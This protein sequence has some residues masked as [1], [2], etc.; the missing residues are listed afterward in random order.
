VPSAAATQRTLIPDISGGGTWLVIGGELPAIRQCWIDWTG[1]RSKG[2]SLRDDGVH[3][4]SK[5]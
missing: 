5:A 2:A 4:A 1:N 3:G